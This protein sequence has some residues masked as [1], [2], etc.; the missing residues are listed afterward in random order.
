LANLVH[1]HTDIGLARAARGAGLPYVLST[2]A[3]TSL[4]QV[5]AAAP[6]SWFQLYVG[7]DQAIVDDLI[8]RAEASGF[9][10]LVVTADVP[11]PGKRLRDLD[12]GFVL[13]L[14]L[15]PK[16]IS[17]V[18]AHP[19]WLF[20]YLRNGPPRFENLEPYSQGGG[21]AKGLAA[22]MASQSTARLDWALFEQIRRRWK[23]PLVL[24]GVLDPAD[25]VKA[26][27]T[28]ADGLIV[29]NHGGRQLNC[30]VAPLDAL[31]QVVDAV[32]P[33][34]PVMMDGGVRC[35]EDV[36]MALSLGARL[37][38]LG[39]PFLYAVGA[40]G[41]KIGPPMLIRNLRDEFDRAMAHLGCSTIADLAEL[42][43]V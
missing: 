29:S 43:V 39:R 33:N 24:K 35:G 37:V 21:A 32:G 7:K 3:T 25:A 22:F 16:L 8:A 20:G 34:V 14:R 19:A 4:E 36:A 12:N 2:A 18:L 17:E 31:P 5:A 13:P 30:A 1:G 9:A 26:V 28:G 42:A 15:T 23:G 10:V 38:F 41:P 11:A 27:E 6:G 40:L